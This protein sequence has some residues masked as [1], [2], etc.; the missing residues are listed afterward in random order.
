MRYHNSKQKWD[1]FNWKQHSTEFK[2]VEF[3]K[4]RKTHSLPARAAICTAAWCTFVPLPSWHYQCWYPP[5]K[6]TQTPGHYRRQISQNTW[7]SLGTNARNEPSIGRYIRGRKVTTPRVLHTE[8]SEELAQGKVRIHL[9]PLSN[10]ERE[11]DSSSGTD[12]TS[13]YPTRC[14]TGRMHK[15]TPQILANFFERNK[16]NPRTTNPSCTKI[17]RVNGRSA[18]ACEGG[19]K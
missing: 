8:Y 7:N 11:A 19:R 16:K 9:S 14:G 6:K 10:T 17:A 18:S 1:S 2:T 12:A 3:Q 15:T 13:H 4:P 5:T